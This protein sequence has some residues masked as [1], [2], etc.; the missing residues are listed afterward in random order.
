VTTSAGCSWTAI[1]NATWITV[2]SGIGGTGTALVSFSVA[3]YTGTGTRSGTLSIAGQT[4]TV[5]QGDAV[6]K[7]SNLR[8]VTGQGN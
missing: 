5:T 3:P 7:P 1:S 8:L 4:V 2:N 6:S